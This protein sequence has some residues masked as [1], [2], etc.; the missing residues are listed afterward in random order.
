MLLPVHYG[1]L[2]KFGEHSTIIHD[3]ERMNEILRLNSHVKFSSNKVDVTCCLHLSRKIMKRDRI[4]CNLLKMYSCLF[5]PNCIRNQLIT[6]TYKL[7]SLYDPSLFHLDS[8]FDVNINPLV[9]MSN[10]QIRSRYF[11]PLCKRFLENLRTH[12]RRT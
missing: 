2:G 8:N 3:F 4:F 9:N 6:C 12:P 1:A 7:T 10:L 11:S 5:I